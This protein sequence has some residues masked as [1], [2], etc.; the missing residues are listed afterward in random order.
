VLSAP[1][2]GKNMV[3]ALDVKKTAKSF[4]EARLLQIYLLQQKI[5]ANA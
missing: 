5:D 3:N 1:Y 4:S 2:G